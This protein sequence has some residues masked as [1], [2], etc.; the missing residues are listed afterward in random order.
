MPTVIARARLRSAQSREA[1][2]MKRLEPWLQS[3][4]VE[5]SA[6]IARGVAH[7]SAIV[8]RPVQVTQAM[9]SASTIRM[10]M[11]LPSAPSAVTSPLM[12]M[13]CWPTDCNMLP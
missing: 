3:V 4:T 5:S 10:G 12:F 13:A 9:L 7:V 11:C 2:L 6:L 1:L 8:C